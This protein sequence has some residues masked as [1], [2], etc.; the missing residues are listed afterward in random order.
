MAITPV[1]Y[2]SSSPYATTEYIEGKFLDILNYK[3]LPAEADDIYQ[4]IGATYEYRPDLMSF[5]LYKSPE[6][7]FVFA[8]R[9][10]DVLIDPV[11]DFKAETKIYIP[12][13]NT[14]L[15]YLGR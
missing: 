6:Y 12:K 5:D 14:V 8:L 10:R 4:A 7:W 2:R 1:V 3:K 11:W 13:L 15:R 9:N